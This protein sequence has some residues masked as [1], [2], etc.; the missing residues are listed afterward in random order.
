[1]KILTFKWRPANEYRTE[2]TAQAVNTLSNMLKRNIDTGFDYEFICVTDNKDG[3][4]QEIRTMPL[5]KN[6]APAHGDVN[7]PNCFYRLRTFAEDFK[8]FVG[9]RFM[10]LDLDCIITGNITPLLERPEDFII[11][12][13]TNMRNYYNGSMVMMNTGSRKEVWDKFNAHTSPNVAKAKGFVGSDQAWISNVL[14][15]DEARFT[16]ADGVYS[17]QGDVMTDHSGNLPKNAKI[18]F[19]QGRANPWD[20]DVQAVHSWVREHYR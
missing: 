20:T 8:H 15:P 19:F 17:Y 10:W 13:A 5:W 14:G 3:I 18:V 11:N 2:F 16:N 4:D 1:M 6:P 9:P 7:K 12:R